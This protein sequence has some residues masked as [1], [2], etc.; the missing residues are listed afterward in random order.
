MSAVL[1]EGERVTPLELFFDLVFVLAITQCTA[2][3]AADQTW[4]GLAQGMLVLGVLWWSWVGYAWL[5]SVV[6]PEEGAVRFAIFGAMA[7]FLIAAIAV[8]NAFGSLGLE[9]A[10]AY[11]AVRWAQIALFVLASRDDP[12][13]RRSVG[14]L[15]VGTAIGVGLLV[16][17]SFL[18]GLAQG[19]LWALAL[20][21]DMGGPYMFGSEGWKLVPGHFAERHGLIIII[22]LGESIVAIGLGAHAHLTYGIAAAAALGI[23]LAAALWWMYFD[24]VALVSRRRLVSAPEGRERN[25][26]ARDSYSY[27]HFP[28]V[29]GIVLGA[30]GLEETLAH[31]GEHLHTVPA[32]ALLGGVSIYL[33]ALVGFRYRQV[34]TVNRRRLAMAILLIALLPVATHV[35]ALV[36]LAIVTALL[37][38]LIAYETRL[39]GEGRGQIRHEDVLPEQSR[40]S[41]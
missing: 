10:L 32:F 15:A 24:V 34:R 14:G 40:P 25:E 41:G 13:L 23:A 26:L 35:P 27:L 17:A 31:V 29:A 38:A 5:T 3:M 19:G 36:T 18:D 37:A 16:A 9:F 20:A 30:L 21:L 1:R 33:L 12:A 7:G 6:D 2:L 39:Y 4:S 8:P 22:A 11:G 28:M